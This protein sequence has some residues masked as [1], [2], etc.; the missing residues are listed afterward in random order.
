MLGGRS[1]RGKGGATTCYASEKVELARR[2]E[3][4]EEGDVES[5][6]ILR[7]SEGSGGCSARG[8]V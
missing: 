7:G 3:E 4:E 2:E 5:T 6:L 1:K 8:N